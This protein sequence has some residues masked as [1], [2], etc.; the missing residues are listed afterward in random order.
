MEEYYRKRAP[1]YERT[2]QR[3]DAIRLKEQ[4]QIAHALKSALKGKEVLEVATGTG[5]WTRFLSE[6]AASITATDYLDEPL[7]FAKAKSYSCP[8]T[9][10]REDA[11]HLSFNDRRFS[12]GMA[13]LWMSHVPKERLAAFFDEFHRVLTNG[14]QV[15][16]ADSVYVPNQ[17]G[18]LVRVDGDANT[19]KLRTLEDG[20]KHTILK[21]YYTSTELL[22]FFGRFTSDLKESDLFFGKHF[23][24]VQYTLRKL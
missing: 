5:Y 14:A 11:Y 20:S 16:I 24:Y 22:A 6:T 18:K 17:G 3:D 1:E 13:L 2:Y 23:W 21:N 12:G 7:A 10:C 19:Y 4:Q 8:I 15:F 9:F